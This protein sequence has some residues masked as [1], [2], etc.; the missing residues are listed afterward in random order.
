MKVKHLKRKVY[1]TFITIVFS[2]VFLVIQFL[3]YGALQRLAKVGTFIALLLQRRNKRIMAANIKIAF[4]ES[5]QQRV[6]EI[7]QKSTYSFILTVLESSWFNYHPHKLTEL[8]ECDPEDIELLRGIQMQKRGIIVIT[9]H[10]GNWE[11]TSTYVS[12]QGL[13]VSVIARKVKIPF[14]DRLFGKNREAHGSKI[15]ESVGAA[16]GLYRA[17]RNGHITGMLMDQN[18]KPRRGGVFC[19]FFGLPVPTTRMPASMILR[20]KAKALST[21]CLHTEKE[22]K[23]SFSPID[24]PEDMTDEVELTQLLLKISEELIRKHPEEWLW[25]YERFRYIS[26]E[27]TPEQKKRMPFYAMPSAQSKK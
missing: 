20:A 15:I 21:T 17:L 9:A 2:P 16:R 10:L 3:P 22:L 26:P 27:I 1:S 13:K 18:T 11:A 6:N 25:N 4:P 19:D 23:L 7:I 24:I 5:D 8:I 12:A 14:L